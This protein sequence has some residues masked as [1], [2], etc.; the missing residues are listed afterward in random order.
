MSEEGG[1]ETTT[2]ERDGNKVKVTYERIIT[3]YDFGEGKRYI[4]DETAEED[5]PWVQVDSGWADWKDFAE[6]TVIGRGNEMLYENENYELKDGRYTAK[7]SFLTE[8]MAQGGIEGKVELYFDYKDGANIFSCKIENTDGQ[9]L[10]EQIISVTF[11]DTTV[12]LP[13]LIRGSEEWREFTPADLYA[14]IM[15]GEG[16]SGRVFDSLMM[17]G[18]RYSSESFE[19][20]YDGDE[21]WCGNTLGEVGSAEY[22]AYF[23]FGE[24][25][26]YYEDENGW[27]TKDAT[28]GDWKTLVEEFFVGVD[29]E[30]LLDDNRYEKRDDGSYRMNREEA[31]AIWEDWKK[32]EGFSEIFGDQPGG[33]I[34]IECDDYIW[35]VR[36]YVSSNDTTKRWETVCTFEFGDQTVELPETA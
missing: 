22:E 35:E 32:E 36:I 11:G 19:Y 7:E 14:S 2:I 16:A 31:E 3:Y 20:Q 30:V 9:L 24:G 10:T 26:E 34:Q 23:D 18:E 17:V 4:R 12:E 5:D 6:S 13:T 15:S 28:Y 27:Q 8:A 1:S 29:L 21:L 33:S 25:L